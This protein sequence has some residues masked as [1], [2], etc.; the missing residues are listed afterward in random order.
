MSRKWV[1][2]I[3]AAL[4]ALAYVIMPYHLGLTESQTDVLAS[5]LLA[6]GLCVLCYEDHKVTVNAAILTRTLVV[7]FLVILGSTTIVLLNH[8]RFQAL[9]PI[10][11][12]VGG[13]AYWYLDR[14]KA[15]RHNEN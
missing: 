8:I 11:M 10:C 1:L 6:V 14:Q 5:A 4:T 12:V 7:I 3:A 15:P 2:I 13:V 9:I